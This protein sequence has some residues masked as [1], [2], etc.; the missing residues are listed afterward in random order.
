MTSGGDD[1]TLAAPAAGAGTGAAPTGDDYPELIVVDRAHYAIGAE[2]ARGGMG[3]ISTARDR[4]L[5]RAIA[6]KELL[7]RDADLAA[8]FEREARITAQLQHPSIVNVHEAGRWSTGEP[9][10]AMKLVAGRPLDQAI[11]EAKTLAARLALLPH[12]IAV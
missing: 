5:G 2:L 10:Y 8:R 7:V 12:A 4:R 9:F 11:A 3:K 1:D 6:I